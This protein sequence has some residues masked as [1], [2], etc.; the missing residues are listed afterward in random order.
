M[1]GRAYSRL[2]DASIEIKCDFQVE[3]FDYAHMV[4]NNM[5]DC[6]IFEAV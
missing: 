3:G 5:R 1:V 4:A 6:R 2:A